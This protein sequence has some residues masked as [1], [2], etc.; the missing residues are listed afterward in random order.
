MVCILV[1]C[2]TM[3]VHDCF[4]L[5]E[6]VDGAVGPG[7]SYRGSH[8]EDVTHVFH[9]HRNTFQEPM[10]GGCRDTIERTAALQNLL[11]GARVIEQ[12]DRNCRDGDQESARHPDF[13]SPLPP[14]PSLLLT[15]DAKRSFNKTF[16]KLRRAGIYP[17][18][19]FI[20]DLG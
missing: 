1:L 20:S 7:G 4:W 3:E 9:T 14:E 15:Y 10:H 18:S 5:S 2:L 16:W 11:Q 12:R 13:P 8:L 17:V 6:Q 19:S